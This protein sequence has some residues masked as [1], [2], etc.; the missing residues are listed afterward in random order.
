MRAAAMSERTQELMRIVSLR[1]AFEKL[2]NKILANNVQ[3]LNEQVE[4]VGG[5]RDVC[6]M[7]ARSA[8]Q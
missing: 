1:N 5:V 3:S 6:C 8:V 4:Q 2:I 7:H